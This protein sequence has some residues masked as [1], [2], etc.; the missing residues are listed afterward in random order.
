MTVLDAFVL[1]SI[2]ALA[3]GLGA[4]PVYAFDNGRS[5]LG[6]LW[7]MAAGLMAAISVLDL[8]LPAL[9]SPVPLAAGGVAGV[10]FVLVAAR[11]LDDHHGDGHAHHIGASPVSALS[12]LMFLVFTVHSAPEGVGI[13]SALKEGTVTGLIVVFAIAVHNIPE[14]TAV[15]VGLRADG[16]GLGHAALYAIVTSLP[17]PLLAPLVFAVAVGPLI[18][19]GM[20]FA[21]G[22]MLALVVTEMSPQGLEQDRVG[23]GLGT[24]LG[25]ALAVL[26]N[27]VLPVPVGV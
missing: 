4:I 15:S 9:G 11:L 8:L 16:V 27:L 26:L 13:G 18:P 14:G 1:G 3:T 20:A 5:G 23:F 6:F 12:L 21:G 17:Q 7:G 22:A 19:A 25:V 10:V 24:A 2:T